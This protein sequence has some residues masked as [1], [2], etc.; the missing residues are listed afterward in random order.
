MSVESL[1]ATKTWRP[2]PISGSVIEDDPPAI[3]S[4]QPVIGILALQGDVAEHRVMLERLGARIRDVKLPADLDGLDGLILPGGESTTMGKL[5]RRFGLL[6]PIRAAARDGLAIY[7][8]C[9]GMILLSNEIQ[10]PGDDQ[11]IIG[12]M[13]I[14]VER[15][16]FGPQVESFESDIE[17]PALPGGPFHGVFIRAPGVVSVGPGVEV[18]ARLDDNTPVAARQGNMLVTSFH[19]ELTR[20]G[21]MHKLFLHLVAQSAPSTMSAVGR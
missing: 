18:L 19:P 6:E 5:M 8:T 16:A 15:N 4:R 13:D 9:A 3:D 21:R 17:I 20:D 11:P 2:R 10:D 1:P 7:G 14:T 12:G